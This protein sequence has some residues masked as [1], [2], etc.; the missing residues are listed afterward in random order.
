MRFPVRSISGRVFVFFLLVLISAFVLLGT[1]V[2]QLFKEQLKEEFCFRVKSELQLIEEA[3]IMAFKDYDYF[4]M[5]RLFSYFL[6]KDPDAVYLK[7]YE[8]SPSSPLIKVEKEKWK[9]LPWCGE[10]FLEKPCILVRTKRIKDKPIPLNL[11]I[12]YS[13]ERLYLK[14]RRMKET[15]FSFVFV[16]FLITVSLILFNI[17]L[18]KKRLESIASSVKSWKREGI[19]GLVTRTENDE[20]APLVN[21]IKEMYEEIEKEREIDRILFSLTTKILEISASASGVLE[22][23]GEVS[24]LLK[25]ELKLDYVKFV[26]DYNPPPVKEGQKVIKLEK[27]PHIY[28]V[29]EGDLPYW[30]EV[31]DIIKNIVD[32]ALLSVFERRRSEDLFMSTITALANAIDAMS[33][34]TKGHSERVAKIAVEIGESMGLDEEAIK[35]LQIGGI[36]HDIGK[37]G[38]PCSILNKPGRL[39]PEEYEKVKQHPVIGYKILKPIRELKDILPIV[40]YHHERCDGS[41]YPDGLKCNQIPM[42][43]RI[44]AVAD[45]IEAMTAERPYKRSYPLEEVLSYLKENA[46]EDK[47]F[48]PQVVKIADVISDR[49]KRIIEAR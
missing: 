26:R 31:K 37:I 14:L 46:G 20:F 9:N 32:S 35:N 27:N 29:F 24:S 13:T 39:T 44:V 18:L 33:P 11:E 30:N 8:F 25:K 2:T 15:F 21:S 34:W 17:H 23:F 41:G 16:L 7:I 28:I 43:A 10:E 40:L 36:L 48:D 3:S 49:I 12:G 47:L 22:F 38:I 42:L 45:V 6:R 19:E 4:H 5:Y 1:Y